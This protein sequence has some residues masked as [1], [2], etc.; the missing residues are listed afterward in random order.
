MRTPTLCSVILA[1]TLPFHASAEEGPADPRQAVQQTYLEYEEAYLSGDWDK[2][3]KMQKDVQRKQAMLDRDQKQNL[4]YIRDTVDGFQPEWWDNCSSPTPVSFPAE[5]WDKKFIANYKPSDHLGLQSVQATG[6]YRV[7]RSGKI[8]ADIDGLNIIV[9]WKPQLIDN[10]D[11]ASGQLAEAHGLT[12]GDVA[13]VI[14]WHE[15]GHNYVTTALPLEHVVTLYSE[16]QL[17]FS[18]LQ[19]FY[20]D[21]TALHHS[22]PRA[23]R[24]QLFIR[25][26]GLDYYDAGQPHTRAGHGIGAILM[27]DMLNNPEA[28]P[29]VR[30]P[31]AV[32]GQQVELNTIIYV[33]ENWE[34]DWTVAEVRRFTGL[35]EGFIKK[36]GDRTLRRKGEFNL[37]NRLKFDLMV[38]QDGKMQQRRDAWIA[39]QLE[40]LIASGRADPMPEDGYAP[41][42]RRELT[43]TSEKLERM[44]SE[45]DKKRLDIPF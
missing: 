5:I 6:Q 34:T 18:H 44:Q 3:E 24:I 20:A 38:A 22:S 23:K 43:S 2:V 16:H 9:T 36:Q 39:K 17:L 14:A 12:L 11:P 25:L 1:L 31:P 15:L 27:V 13:E 40:G 37:P 41:A 28:W 45:P 33:Y 26:H 4:K 42:E 29:S 7:S 19:E 21:L 30:F 35:I 8:K 10:P 32:P